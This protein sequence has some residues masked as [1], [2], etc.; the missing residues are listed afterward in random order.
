MKQ[1]KTKPASEGDHEKTDRSAESNFF[2]KL[3]WHI[4]ALSRFLGVPVDL[5]DVDQQV[6]DTAGVTPLVV[7]PGD[8]LDKVLV[9]GDTG[10][11]IED[12]RAVVTAH[13]SGDDIVLGVAEY[14]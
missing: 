5:G 4:R 3:T 10:L 14:A 8:K 1:Q 11:S 13:V 9:Q 7:V 12:G 2:L 6:E